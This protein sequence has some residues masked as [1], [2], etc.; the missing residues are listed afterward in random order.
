MGCLYG[1]N[2]LG[3]LGKAAFVTATR[4]ARRSVVMAASERVE[5]HTPVRLGQMLELTGRVVRVGRSSMTVE[6]EGVA[7]TLPGGARIPA[8]R[9]RFEM[10]AVDD[11]GR[12]QAILVE[13]EALDAL[14]GSQ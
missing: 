7:E 2:A 14:S 5:F 12:P 9:G 10:V 4:F 11:A 6:V 1:G 8:L 13:G 3:I